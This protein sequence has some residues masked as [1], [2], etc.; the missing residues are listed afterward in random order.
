MRRRYIVTEPHSL[1]EGLYTLA[2]VQVFKMLLLVR[3]QDD[4]NRAL[5]L[6]LQM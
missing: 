5:A 4:G 3:N 2:M 6:L 1:P